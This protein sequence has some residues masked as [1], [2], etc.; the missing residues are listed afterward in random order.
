M[1]RWRQNH[2]YLLCVEKGF[3][4]EC[5]ERVLAKVRVKPNAHT[6]PVGITGSMKEPQEKTT[7][8]PQAFQ[9]LGT[10]KE[11]AKQ[12][13]GP[14]A[15]GSPQVSQWLKILTRLRFGLK[16]HFEGRKHL[17]VDQTN[18]QTNTLCPSLFTSPYLVT[19]FHLDVTFISLANV[20]CLPSKDPSGPRV[21]N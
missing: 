21:G 6:F 1:I 14:V 13:T 3:T 2:S 7:Q 20:Y 5:V 19:V 10:Q 11:R 8:E 9:A 12:L 4:P 17:F 15:H 16:S 18:K